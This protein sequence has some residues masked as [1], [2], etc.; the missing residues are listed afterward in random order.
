[1]PPDD[2]A[3]RNPFRMSELYL[4]DQARELGVFVEPV[5]VWGVYR[6]DGGICQL[7]NEP[8]E[9]EGQDGLAP[10]LDHIVPFNHGGMHETANVQLA[11]VYCNQV[12][13]DAPW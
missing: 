4:R 7:C 2:W 13:G 3:Q 12:K 1:M 11:H 10:S 6:R 5:D 9:K 8:V